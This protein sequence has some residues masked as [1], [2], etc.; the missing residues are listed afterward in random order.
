MGNPETGLSIFCLSILLSIACGVALMKFMPKF[1]VTRKWMILE[2][3]KANDKPLKVS[4]SPRVKPGDVGEASSTLRPIGSGMFGTEKVE[5][6]SDGEFLKKG[7]AIEV[8]RV[9]GQKVVVR[10]CTV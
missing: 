6:I 7:A 2:A 4:S 5:V 3:P 9:E 10:S 8:I 1:V